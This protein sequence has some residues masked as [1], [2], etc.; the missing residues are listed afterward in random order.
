MDEA[1][2]KNPA[3]LAGFLFISRNASYPAGFFRWARTTF[4]VPASFSN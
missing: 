4:Q 3:V 2:K 1:S